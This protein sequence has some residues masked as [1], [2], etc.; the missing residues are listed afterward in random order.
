[1]AK[2]LTWKS[3]ALTLGGVLLGLSL[4]L[5]QHRLLAQD[6]QATDSSMIAFTS[7][8]GPDGKL[9]CL[10]DPKEK[11][12]SIYE[13]DLKK[14]KLKLAAVRHVGAD[15]Q[16]AEFN[17]EEPSVSKIEQLVRRR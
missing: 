4:Q 12:L 10:I 5:G 8:N 2:Y 7:E 6:K 15:H 1:M 16:L 9:F 17:N 13:F 3:L 14:S 11:V